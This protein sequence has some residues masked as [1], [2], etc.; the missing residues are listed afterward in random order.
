MTVRRGTAARAAA[1]LAAAALAL[2]ACGEDPGLPDPATPPPVEQPG[3][4]QTGDDADGG[5]APGG[6][7]PGDQPP[8]DGEAPGDQTPGGADGGETPGGED[9]GGDDG[10]PAASVAVDDDGGVGANGPAILRPER[11]RLVVE[12]DVQEGVAPEQA[13]LDHLLA[14]IRRHA[15]KPAGIELS[16]GNTFASDREQWSAADVRA[17]ADANRATA[18]EGDT[19]SLYLVYLRGELVR[20]GESSNALG[21]AVN[22]S[23]VALF[24]EQWSDLGSA[25]LGSGAAVERAVLVHEL[26]HAL[27]LVNLTYDSPIDHEDPEH[28]GHS[29]N[30]ES[31]MYW[32][33]ETTAIGQVFSGPPPD[34]FD[35]ADVTDIQII[36]GRE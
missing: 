31:V 2:V 11:P 32:A 7:A 15:D 33:V 24:P 35:D 3:G 18:S 23:E 6:G 36:A 10:G 28:P 16:G 29:S 13:A 9:P 25:L 27:G 14:T 8:G 1:V 4:G 34:T 26:G 22:A 17:I 12:V 20:D 5:E 30:R 21:V 19:V